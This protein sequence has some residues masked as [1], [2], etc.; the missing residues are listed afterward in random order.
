M[1]NILVADAVPGEAV[2][3]SSGVGG[4]TTLVYFPGGTASAGVYTDWP[5]F[6]AAIAALPYSPAEVLID[7]SVAQALVPA[8]TWDLRGAFDRIASLIG[9]IP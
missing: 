2:W 9:P 5:T 1:P 4:D 8:G 3:E 6:L 7:T